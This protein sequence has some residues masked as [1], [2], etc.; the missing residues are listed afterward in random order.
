M[1]GR[2]QLI[3]VPAWRGRSDASSGEHAGKPADGEKEPTIAHV[4]AKSAEQR[5][6]PR[7][8]LS[9]THRRHGRIWDYP[10]CRG[11]AGDWLAVE[12]VHREPVSVGASLQGIFDA[13]EFP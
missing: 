13:F 2:D 1:V 3:Q 9:L 11:S 5:E 6:P 12:A 7:P 8:A 4:G 10:P